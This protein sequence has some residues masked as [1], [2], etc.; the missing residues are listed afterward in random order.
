[1][2]HTIPNPSQP[3]GRLKPAHLVTDRALRYRANAEPPAGPEVC[4][5]CGATGKLD[6]EHID[7]REEN[8]EPENKAYA[9]RSCNTTKGA[10]FAALDIGRRTRQFNPGPRTKT[11]Y[12]IQF[13]GRGKGNQRWTQHGPEY[14]TPAEAQR[15]GETTDRQRFDGR[16]WAEWRVWRKKPRA[17]NPAA[18][19]AASTAA[20]YAAAVVDLL[21]GPTKTAVQKAIRIVKATSAAKR[22]QFAQE[23]RRRNP[24]GTVPTFEQYKYALSIHSPGAY[25][26]GGAIIH[27]TPPAKR[28][29][30]ARR[31]WAGRKRT[32]GRSGRR[33]M[34]AVPF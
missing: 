8:N 24:A 6:V 1:M 32:Y 7:G 16:V 17:T 19:V 27:A 30:Y 13:R 22:A 3:S 4:A 15:A 11:A 5:Y 28:S 18:A 14:A 25:D 31:L 26:E 29:E 2:H 20:K 23:M 12:V 33:E 21:A 34:D 10:T 9:C